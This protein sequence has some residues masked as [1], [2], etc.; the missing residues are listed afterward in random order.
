[1]TSSVYESGLETIGDERFKLTIRQFE[2]CSDSVCNIVRDERCSVLSLLF[3]ALSNSIRLSIV[4]N[5][6]VLAFFQNLNLL[7]SIL[8]HT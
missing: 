4:P 2:L 7:K 5:P 6:L 3:K 1:M 8:L